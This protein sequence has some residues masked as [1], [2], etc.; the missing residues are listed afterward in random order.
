MKNIFYLGFYDHL[1]TG[2]WHLYGFDVHYTF[3]CRC[4]TVELTDE[5]KI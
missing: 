3:N 1:K 2:H 4:V 5:A